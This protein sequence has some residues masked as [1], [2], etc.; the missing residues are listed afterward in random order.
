M[1]SRFNIDIFIIGKPVSVR[2]LLYDLK[3]VAPDV[4][5]NTVLQRYNHDQFYL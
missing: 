2:S 3:D 4:D 1:I 5:E